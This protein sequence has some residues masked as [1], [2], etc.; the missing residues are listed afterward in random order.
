MTVGV[1]L[2][3]QG[4]DRLPCPTSRQVQ[5]VGGHMLRDFW[6]TGHLRCGSAAWQG[7]KGSHHRGGNTQGLVRAQR[8]AQEHGSNTL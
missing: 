3:R 2:P 1:W 7:W 5:A 6:R 4:T 8:E